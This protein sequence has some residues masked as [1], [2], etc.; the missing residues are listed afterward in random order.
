M[1]ET[2][3]HYVPQFYLREFLDPTLKAKGQNVLWLYEFGHRPTKKSVKAVGYANSFYEVPAGIGNA[4]IAEQPGFLEQRLQQLEARA[5]P[6]LRRLA[7][8]DFNLPAEQRGE[9][10]GFIALS[11]CR[12]PFFASMV[13]ELT[14]RIHRV[15]L[16]DALD[17][18]GRLEELMNEAGITGLRSHV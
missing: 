11:M 15:F 18:P 2:R 10:A 8:G 12:T 5:A 1:A 14:M 17:T 3:Q 9:F 4:A 7:K 6:A 13:D 16:R